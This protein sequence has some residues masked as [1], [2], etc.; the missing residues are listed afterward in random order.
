MNTDKT[1]VAGTPDTAVPQTVP[2]T[3]GLGQRT[4]CGFGLAAPKEAD[5]CILTLR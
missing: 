5:W 4:Q 1:R 3:V 2:G